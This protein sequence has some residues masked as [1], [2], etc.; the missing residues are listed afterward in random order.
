[1]KKL[2]IVLMMMGGGLSEAATLAWDA[3]T[4]DITG[5]PET[6][7]AYKAWQRKAG[8]VEVWVKFAETAALSVPVPTPSAKMEYAVSAIDLAGNESGLSLSVTAKPET[9]KNPRVD[10]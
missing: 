7:S 2:L 4:T 3:V 1:M 8:T 5:A 6:I 10:R 9:P